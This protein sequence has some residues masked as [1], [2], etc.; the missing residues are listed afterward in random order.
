M[1]TTETRINEIQKRQGFAKVAI[2]HAKAIRHAILATSSQNH[3]II[4]AKIGE[5]RATNT[6]GQHSQ[7]MRI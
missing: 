3:E 7:M 2:S 1:L 6:G 5:K 4:M